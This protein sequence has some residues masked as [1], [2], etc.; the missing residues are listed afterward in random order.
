M[1]KEIS[2]I[3]GDRGNMLAMA[4]LMITMDRDNRK[5]SIAALAKITETQ[6]ADRRFDPAEPNPDSQS[7][8]FQSCKYVI[9]DIIADLC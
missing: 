1:K 9:F 6:Y 5:E 4:E 2:Q 7:T 8:M 3:L